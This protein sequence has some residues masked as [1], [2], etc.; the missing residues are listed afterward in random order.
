MPGGQVPA[1]IPQPQAPARRSSFWILARISQKHLLYQMCGV[2]QDVL[3]AIRREQDG[4][5][6]N[7]MELSTRVGKT[8]KGTGRFASSGQCC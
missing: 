1:P 5:S 4:P 3:G 6:R 2:T 7:F 8:D